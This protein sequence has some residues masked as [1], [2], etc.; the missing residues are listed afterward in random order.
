MLRELEDIWIGRTD[1]LDV[2]ALLKRS[3]MS[4]EIVCSP[5]LFGLQLYQLI[6]RYFSFR[7][8]FMSGLFGTCK[9][10]GI[11]VIMKLIGKLCFL[12]FVGYFGQTGICLFFSKVIVLFRRLLIQVSVGRKVTLIPQLINSIRLY[13]FCYKMASSGE[14]LG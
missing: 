10:R 4:L 7:Y 1:F 2:M 3:S 5:G 14:G 13:Y 11:V 9:I 12:L 8:L 6:S